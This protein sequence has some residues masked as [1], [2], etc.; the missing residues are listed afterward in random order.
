MFI[1]SKKKPT[2]LH[3]LMPSTYCDQALVPYFSQ[4]ET[5]NSPFL[6]DTEIDSP[7]QP[8][9]NDPLHQETEN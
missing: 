7:I 6:Q 9:R 4:L 3:E 2:I 5:L 1:V 8:E